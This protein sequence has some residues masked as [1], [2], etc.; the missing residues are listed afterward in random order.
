[1]IP[2]NETQVVIRLLKG[3][4]VHCLQNRRLYSRWEKVSC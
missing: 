3:E 2:S 4:M 1:M